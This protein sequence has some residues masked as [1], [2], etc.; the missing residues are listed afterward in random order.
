MMS[1]ALAG[2]FKDKLII[3]LPGSPK[4]AELALSKL[5]LPEAGH[6]VWEARR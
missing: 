5:V 2:V 1:R 3:C 4:A 6:M